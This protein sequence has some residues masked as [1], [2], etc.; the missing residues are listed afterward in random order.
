MAGSSK[1]ECI[2]KDTFD[3]AQHIRFLIFKA[4]LYIS[5]NYIL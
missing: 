2:G 1:P 3:A 5:K 4:K